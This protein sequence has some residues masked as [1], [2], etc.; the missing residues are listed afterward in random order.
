M[1]SILLNVFTQ[2]VISGVVLLVITK[3]IEGNAKDSQRATEAEKKLIQREIS[4][5]IVK[6][7]A[8]EH[9]NDKQSEE[10][11]KLREK[12][13]VLIQTMDDAKLRIFDLTRTIE[14]FKVSSDHGK[15]IVK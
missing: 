5:L 15:V 7:T 13:S 6:L 4:D 11:V 9:Q 14:A 1:E 3:Y 12:V 8:L 10:I 2:S